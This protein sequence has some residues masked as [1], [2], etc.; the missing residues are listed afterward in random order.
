MQILQ[1]IPHLSKGGAER[2]VVELTNSLIDAGHEVTILLGFPVDPVLNQK[3]LNNRVN[4]QFISHTSNSRFLLYSKIPFYFLR[5]WKRLKTYNVIHCHLTFGLVFGFLS[6]LFRRV[7][8]AKRLKLVAT[9]HV[10]GVGITRIQRLMNEWLSSCFDEFALVAEDAQWRDFIS[11]RHK[12]NICFVP[13]GIS[14]R[15]WKIR[16]NQRSNRTVWT[17]GTVSRLQKER[18]PWLFLEV[19]SHVHNLTR[20]QTRFILGGDGPEK[21]KLIALSKK[22]DIS[23]ELSMLGLVNNPKKVLDM[24][25]LY[26]GLNVEKTSG[27]AGLEAVFSGVPTVSIQ[28]SPTFRPGEGDWIWSHQDP[29]LVARQITTLLQ[30]FDQLCDLADEQYRVAI[31]DY[32]VEK[33]RDSYLELYSRKI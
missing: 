7:T 11:V 33:M 6:Y 8:R 21:E 19:F 4:I 27:I 14:A 20:G 5:N 28:L 23:E 22:L 30:D 24:V 16:A 17:I 13:N 32:S 1:V 29:L 25:D 31:R 10:V 26:V 3:K 9:C 12:S 15:E 18:M 2:V